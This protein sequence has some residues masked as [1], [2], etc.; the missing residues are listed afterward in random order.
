MS[1][2][3]P[4]Y[5]SPGNAGRVLGLSRTKVMGLV[6]SGRLSAVVLDNR[7]RITTESIEA[8]RSSLPGYVPGQI[9]LHPRS[10]LPK[11]R[12]APKVAS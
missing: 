6:R 3:K 10:P 12:P 11:K 7:I 8:L 5:L 4:L 1:E 9:D 2:I